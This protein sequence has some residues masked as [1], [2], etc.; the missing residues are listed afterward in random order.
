MAFVMQIPQVQASWKPRETR[1]APDNRVC[2]SPFSAGNALIP[3]TSLACQIQEQISHQYDFHFKVKVL[4][5]CQ[6]RELF[7][8][9]EIPPARHLYL[10]DLCSG[11]QRNALAP[12]SYRGDQQLGEWQV[13]PSSCIVIPFWRLVQLSAVAT[14]TLQASLCG[15]F[16][17]YEWVFCRRS[18][19]LFWIEEISK[20][21]AR[22]SESRT[23]RI[24]AFK[25]DHLTSSTPFAWASSISRQQR[26]LIALLAVSVHG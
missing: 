11:P 23:L 9:V 12:T 1:S 10:W 7:S 14:S 22:A 5:F 17:R 8:T 18:W 26:I 2:A 3:C 6:E 16:I 20:Q 21:P 19:S 24:E 25:K 13:N 15:L 4:R